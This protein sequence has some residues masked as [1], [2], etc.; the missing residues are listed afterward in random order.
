MVGPNPWPCAATLATR[1]RGASSGQDGVIALLHAHRI[2]GCQIL[3]ADLAVALDKLGPIALNVQLVAVPV[4]P[5]G[6]NRT[7]VAA[8]L[9]QPSMS[10]RMTYVIG[11]ASQLQPVWKA[12]YVTAVR[13]R[14]SRELVTPNVRHLG[15]VRHRQLMTRYGP[16]FRRAQI[17][18]DVPIL[19]ASR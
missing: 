19:I 1:A 18:D 10:D 4:D 16:A 9:R 3:I 11:P 14:M 7:S 8:F 12:W 15:R 17:I 5:R 13:D 2:D 6:D